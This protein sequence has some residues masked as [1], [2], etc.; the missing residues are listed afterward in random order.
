MPLCIYFVY[1]FTDFQV[2]RKVLDKTVW[3]LYGQYTVQQ[4]GD[5]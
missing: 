2:S 4:R 5:L 1:K 3:L